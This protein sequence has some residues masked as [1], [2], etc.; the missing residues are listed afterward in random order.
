[1]RCKIIGDGGEGVVT[2]LLEEMHAISASQLKG[3][4]VICQV[5]CQAK[6]YVWV[7]RQYYVI[8]KYHS[9][10]NF[11]IVYATKP[12]FEFVSIVEGFD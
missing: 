1:M 8:I 4:L 10:G 11:N 3:T 12:K 6:A 7:K 2:F 5:N 9:A